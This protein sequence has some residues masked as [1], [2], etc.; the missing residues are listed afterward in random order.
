MN[1]RQEK[2]KR[3]GHKN[4]QRSK[5][6]REQ[7]TNALKQA[8]EWV[9]Q[10]QQEGPAFEPLVP[11]FLMEGDFLEE[12][13]RHRPHTCCLSMFE[14]FPDPPEEDKSNASAL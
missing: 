14:L 11:T 12:V 10:R 9:Q 13:L 7:L 2:P 8:A 6:E 3:I 1:D 4:N 5:Q